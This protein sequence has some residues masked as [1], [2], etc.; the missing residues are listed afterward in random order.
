M[1]NLGETNEVLTGLVESL[2]GDKV[3]VAE[4]KEKKLKAYIGSNESGTTWWVMKGGMPVSQKKTL[5]EILKAYESLG[6]K[7]PPMYWNWKKGNF[8]PVSKIKK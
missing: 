8:I 6:F 1:K 2:C 3:L 4:S 7:E 5:K